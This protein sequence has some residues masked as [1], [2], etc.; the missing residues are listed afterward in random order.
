MKWWYR[1]S[2][3]GYLL[4][5][6]AWIWRW[7]MQLR[8]YLYKHKIF[9]TTEFTVP[10]IV[11]GN[12]TVGGNGKT[13]FI[14]A[15]TELLHELGFKPGIVSRGYGGQLQQDTSEVIATSDPKLVGDEP[16][17]LARRLQCPLVVGKNRVKAVQTLLQNHPCDIVLSDDGLQHLSLGRAMEIII[18]DGDRQ[19]GNG[20]CLP[21]GPLR[22]S[23][24]RLQTTP[25]VIFQSHAQDSAQRF[26]L[27]PKLFRSVKNS[28]ITKPLAAFA[29]QT[30][31]II[32][33]IG[34]PQ[35]FLKTLQTLQ[36]K[37]KAHVFRDHHAYTWQELQ[38]YQHKTVLMTEKDAVKCQA[39]PLQ[40]AWYLEVETVMTDSLRQQLRAHFSQWK[41]L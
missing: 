2:S 32:A 16:V 40:D 4:L 17:L 3:I 13:P 37:L 31:D 10:V 8:A 25:W 29:E 26:F 18:V 1:K 21:A 20:F 34:Y 14:I 5:P 33:A 19:L 15:L 24:K 11:I 28:A 7:G 23:A 22:E 6:L 35:R 12:I 41:K 27:Q 9:T 38:D 39:F 36:I 30:V